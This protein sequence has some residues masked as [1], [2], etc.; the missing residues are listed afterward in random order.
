MSSHQESQTYGHRKNTTHYITAFQPPWKAI[1]NQADVKW[2][3][4]VEEITKS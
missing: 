3:F 4:W 1:S 2:D